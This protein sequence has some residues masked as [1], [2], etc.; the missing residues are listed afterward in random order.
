MGRPRLPTT[1]SAAERQRRYVAGRDLVSVA[2]PRATAKALNDLA[3]GRGVTR[4]VMVED[5]LA[6]WHGTLAALAL[7]VPIEPVTPG[8]APASDR[9]STKAIDGV[10][11]PTRTA[12]RPR[13]RRRDEATEDL[14]GATMESARPASR[15]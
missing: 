10:P 11:R 5:L 13:H 8:P 2:M 4:A 14:F 7:A 9:L 1:L 6:G 3:K 12:P 15:P